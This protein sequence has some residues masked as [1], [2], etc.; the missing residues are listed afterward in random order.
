M[1][2]K[3]LEYVGPIRDVKMINKMKQILKKTSI[4]NLLLFNI[5]INTGIKIHDLLFLKVK[6]VSDGEHIHEFLDIYDNITD[7]KKTFYLNARV[8]ETLADYLKN[9]DLK[10]NDYLFKSNKNDQPISRQ[11]AYR[12]INQAAKEAGFNERI[13]MHTLRKT[14]GYHAYKKGISISI[15]SSIFNHHSTSETYRYLGINYEDR[16]QIKVDVNL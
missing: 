11:Q 8:R 14:F 6:D 12:I 10:L 7:E 15:I 16:Q 1:G 5:G 9:S 13:G 3:T 2:V 4:R